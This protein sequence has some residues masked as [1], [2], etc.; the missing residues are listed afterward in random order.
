MKKILLFVFF[1]AAVISAKP[2]QIKQ[3]TNLNADCRNFNCGRYFGGSIYYTFEA[4]TGSS[5]SVYLGQYFVNSDSFEIVTKVTNDNFINI[6]PKLLYSNDSLFIIYQTNKNGNWDIAYQIYLNKQL[7]P[8]YYVADSL[9]DE[10][11]PVVST[12]NEMWFSS[13]NPSVCYGKGNSVYLKDLHIP[14]SVESE[15]FHGDD[16]TKFTQV[17]QEIALIYYNFYIAARKIVN[18]KSFIVYK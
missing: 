13:Q 18:G 5:S 3:I 1:L 6:N 11:N 8:V 4:H 14:N 9:I 15:I 12:I 2:F 17:S 7:S 16:S 10:T